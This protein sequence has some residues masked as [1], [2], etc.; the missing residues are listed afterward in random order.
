MV[1]D[2]IELATIQAQNDNNYY[3]SILYQGLEVSWYI[4]T[5]NQIAHVILRGLWIGAI[6]L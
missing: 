2:P 1:I 6:G 3:K 4:I 5:I